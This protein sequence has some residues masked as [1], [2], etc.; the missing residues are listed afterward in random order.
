MH[1]ITSAVS[2]FLSEHQNVLMVSRLS[3]DMFFSPQKHCVHLILEK[4][5]HSLSD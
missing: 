3:F 5:E 1:H 2:V 4:M